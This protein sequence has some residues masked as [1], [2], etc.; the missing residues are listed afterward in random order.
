MKKNNKLLNLILPIITI[1]SILLLWSVASISV[2]SEYIL[3]SVSKT[4]SE[5]IN[6]LLD[7][8]FYIAFLLTLLRSLIAFAI[9][10]LLSSIMAFFA[11][12]SKKAEALILPL[13]SIFRALPTI[14]I[15]LLLLFWTNEQVAP[16]I[17]TML[18]VMPTTYT[19]L[20]SALDSVDKSTLE[21]GQVDGADKWQLFSRIQFPQI[22]PAV[23]SAVGSGISLNFKLMVAAEV[24]SATITSLGNMLNTTNFNGEIAKMLAIVCFTVLFGIIIEHTFNK[25]SKIKGDWKQNIK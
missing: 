24:L 6:L 10:F 8:K 5:F 7:T 20:K 23:Y 9:S 3:P 17:V 25:I 14:A 15:V 11:H 18:V 1:V 16:I 21:A 12:K 19:H 2:N 22:S 13:V 4:F